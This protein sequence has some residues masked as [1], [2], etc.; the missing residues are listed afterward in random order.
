MFGVYSALRS[1]RRSWAGRSLGCLV[2]RWVESDE[3]SVGWIPRW[4]E[5]VGEITGGVPSAPRW[6]EGT[7]ICGSGPD[8]AREDTRDRAG[9]QD[10]RGVS[11]GF[12]RY[13]SRTTD[14]IT[15]KVGRAGR[16][17]RHGVAGM[18]ESRTEGGA[19]GNDLWEFEK[20]KYKA[21][22]TGGGGGNTDDAKCIPEFV[23]TPKM[24]SLV[25]CS[26]TVVVVDSVTVAVRTNNVA[27]LVC[28]HADVFSF[29]FG[30]YSFLKV[31]MVFGGLDYGRIR[32][33]G[34]L[35]GFEIAFECST[36]GRRLR[37]GY[38]DTRLERHYNKNI[39]LRHLF[40]ITFK[41]YDMGVN[42]H[43]AK[44]Y[45]EELKLFLPIKLE[46]FE[47]LLKP[48][49]SVMGKSHDKVLMN[50]IKT[51]MFGRLVEHGNGYLEIEK[52]GDSDAKS[53]VEVEVYG[54][55][56]LK[57]GFS[58]K[59]FELGSSTDCLQGSR[60]VLFSLHD[61]FLKL[62]KGAANSGVEVVSPEV[63]GDTN[64]DEVHELV[65]INGVEAK[66]SDGPT[67]KTSK[68]KKKR[69][70]EKD[71]A[72]S[73]SNGSAD[74][75]FKKTKKGK[76][77][78]GESKIS[79]MKKN[80]TRDSH[81]LEV[82]EEMIGNSVLDNEE[83]L[84]KDGEFV[85]NELVIYNLQMQFEKVAAEVGMDVDGGSSFGSPLTPVNGT[86]LKKRE[87]TK[88]SNG[89]KNSHGESVNENSDVGKSSE[90]SVK[91]VRPQMNSNLV[92]RPHN[93]LPP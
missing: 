93:L 22:E 85:F 10:G 61:D 56:A 90:T 40:S 70:L 62:D 28:S 17:L 59:F 31:R 48:F 73:G 18:G 8:R 44:V 27:I 29:G 6:T 11:R 36:G 12:G 77:A 88:I 4:I 68:K 66:A 78:S 60:K 54:P 7:L 41:G 69:K 86:L 74:K 32:L 13:S 39:F 34:I 50:K 49:F 2:E 14:Q 72:N 38:Y 23:L 52:V 30:T 89:K 64:M 81:A 33:R 21:W 3:S 55:A 58:V 45:L 35:V 80:E 16:P 84:S 57:L 5:P 1:P 19:I 25:L 91:K 92:R 20:G 9:I 79:K 76:K 75:G 46:N 43:I 65:P 63:N 37:V 67:D 42:Y 83:S 15:G 82:K 53:S 47:V 26:D 24:S 87:T 71:L 51:Y